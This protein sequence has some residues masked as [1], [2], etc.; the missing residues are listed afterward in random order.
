MPPCSSVAIGVHLWKNAPMSRA[1]I[2]IILLASTAAVA[3]DIDPAKVVDLT[4]PFGA[5]TIY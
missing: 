3:V 4:Y 1:L 5:D 2:A